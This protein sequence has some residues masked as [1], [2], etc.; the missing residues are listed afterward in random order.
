MKISELYKKDRRTLS[1]EIFPPKREENLKNIDE[2][3]SVLCE[4]KP[5][6]ISVTFGAGGSANS[7]NTIAIAKKIKNDYGIEPVVHLTCLS[8]DKHE[9][10]EFA[11]V[12]E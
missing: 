11:K 9:I 1:F 5:D 8:Y 3:L 4:L 2:T 10:D 7:N 6:F 12:L